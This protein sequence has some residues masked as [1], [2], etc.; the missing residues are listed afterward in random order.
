MKITLKKKGGNKRKE[1]DSKEKEKEKE[2]TMAAMYG[3]CVFPFDVNAIRTPRIPSTIPTPGLSRVVLPEDQ[4]Q[5]SFLNNSSNANTTQG[6]TAASYLFQCSTPTV[7]PENCVSRGALNL[8]MPGQRRPVT[9]Q[10]VTEQPTQEEMWIQ[11]IAE[12]ILPTLPDPVVEEGVKIQP[13][14]EEQGTPT[15]PRSKRPPR[16][17]QSR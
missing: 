2:V 7:S 16:Y 12:D 3:S 13:I 4:Q 11:P 5:Y 8:P 9:I 15:N 10:P 14:Y 1:K 6:G 17:S